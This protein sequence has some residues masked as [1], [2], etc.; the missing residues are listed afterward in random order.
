MIRILIVDDREDSRYLLDTLLRSSGYE[1]ESACN[2][3]EALDKARQNPPQLIIADLLM[4]VMDGFT[5][6]RHWRSDPTLKRIPFI[7]HTATYTDAK[8][9][10]L[11]LKLGVMPSSSSRRNQR[12]CSPASASFSTPPRTAFRPTLPRPVPP[13]PPTYPL[14]IR[15]RKRRGI[16]GFIARCSSTSWKT[17]WMPWTGPTTNSG[18][19]TPSADA[20]SNTSSNLPRIVRVERRQPDNRAGKGPAS[21]AG[22]RL[23]YRGG[24]RK[25]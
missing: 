23:P 18:G 16:C 1:V 21:D 8:D 5:L 4:P 25:I 24:K 13:D 19:K 10:E 15:T 2:G 9:E 12:T 22:G 7:V 14:R 20:R 11:A 6:L 3:A 17:K